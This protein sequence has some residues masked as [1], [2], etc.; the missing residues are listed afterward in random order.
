M[1]FH[2][3]DDSNVPVSESVDCHA[4]LERLGRP[5]TLVTVPTG[6]HYDAML[7]QGIPRAIAW[8]KGLDPAQ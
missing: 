5:V 6:D 3:Q 1:L 8:L 7:R 2:A 4:R